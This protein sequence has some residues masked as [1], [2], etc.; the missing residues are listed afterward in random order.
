M[1]THKTKIIIAIVFCTL[2]AGGVFIS[3]CIVKSAAGSVN[4]ISE[5]SRAEI[6]ID[7][8]NTEKVTPSTIPGLKEGNHT[9]ALKKEGYVTLNGTFYIKTNQTIELNLSVE[10]SKVI[11]YAPVSWAT[12]PKNN[13]SASNITEGVTE[14]NPSVIDD[15]K[16]NE[17]KNRSY[18]PNQ[19]NE[20]SINVTIQI[21]EDTS[22]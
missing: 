11:A 17:L 16:F 20:P 12:I 7:G 15:E 18:M 14:P 3:G 4:F 19:S 2:L 5:P 10:S 9:Y 22:H 6:W 21:T 13:I 1:E 8:L